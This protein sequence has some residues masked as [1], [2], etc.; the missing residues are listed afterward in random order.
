MKVSALLACFGSIC[1]VSATGAAS[2][3]FDF[4]NGPQYSGTPLDQVAGGIRAHFDSIGGQGYSIQ[5]I[6][7][8][9]GMLPTGF[10]GLGLSPN[11][12]FPSDLTISFHDAVTSNPLFLSDV[13]MMVA[14]QELACDSSSTM[15]MSAYNGSTFVGSVTA[16]AVA[17]V[18]TWPTIDLAFSSA[19]PFD[20]V[21][22]HFQSGPPTGGDWGP[23]F[24][25]DNLLVNPAPVPEPATLTALGIAAITF[26]RFGRQRKQP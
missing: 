18:Y 1:A 4:N 5:D 9:I 10:S 15:K 21:V 16:V 7:Q 24:V 6:G 23:I 26:A 25:A 8:V 14:P 12:V 13:S 22:I 20:N 17:D 2:V 3:L 19:L 11:S